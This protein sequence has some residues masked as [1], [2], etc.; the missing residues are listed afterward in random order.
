MSSLSV[1]S[2]HDWKACRHGVPDE[3]CVRCHPERAASF[4]A[5]GDWC[6]E[7]D[8]AESQ[9]LKC[10]PE[11]D[12]SPPE[13]PPAGADVRDLVE[14]GQDVPRLEAHLVPGKVTVF[15]FYAVWCLP[16]RRVD[17]RIY[18]VLARRRDVA[19]R[20]I[21]V[22]SWDTPVAQ[23]WLADVAELPLVVIYDRR[24]RKLKSIAGAKLDEIDRAI[25]E[26]SR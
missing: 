12:F 21:N 1:A 5:R 7:H 22:G 8:V 26:A 6:R 2:S 11:L 14:E 9:C 20:K 3:V 16:C 13:K 18:A 19:L 10:S 15:D 25:A 4:K 23:R 17:Q 24:G